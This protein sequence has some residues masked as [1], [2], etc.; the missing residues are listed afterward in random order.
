[1]KARFVWIAITFTALTFGAMGIGRAAD[2]FETE[3]FSGTLT[4]QKPMPSSALTSILS[5]TY[6]GITTWDLTK[7]QAL[8]KDNSL[9]VYSSFIQDGGNVS[10]T[11]K[12]ALGNVTFNSNNLPAGSSVPTLVV[13][14]KEAVGFDFDIKN[15]SVLPMELKLNAPIPNPVSGPNPAHGSPYTGVLEDLTLKVTFPN[16][17]GT[18]SLIATTIPKFNVI[19][20]PSTWFLMIG[21]AAALGLVGIRRRQAV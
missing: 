18:Q 2:V 4:L 1:M 8:D 13:Q 7:V 20:E 17:L 11:L 6:T 21:G 15:S 16:P 10:V 5:L 3:T 9:K 14:N 12:T 19:P